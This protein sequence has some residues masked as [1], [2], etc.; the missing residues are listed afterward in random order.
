[1]EDIVIIAHFC[2]DL[3][4]EGNNRF[5][6]LANMLA[7][8]GHKIEFITSDFSHGKKEKRDT[9]LAL[10][11][12][13]T[14]YIK[15][16]SYKKNISIRR[17]YSHHALGKHL[18][19]YLNHRDKPS[20]IYCAVPSLSAAKAAA[21]YA[22]KNSIP[23]VIDIQDLWPEAFQMVLK[24]PKV[25]NML[26]APMKHQADSIYKKADAIIGV[27]D[28]YVNRGLEKNSK[29]R[30]GYSIY[31]GTDLDV[32]DQMI[33][34]VDSKSEDKIILAYVGTLGHSYDIE[35]TID[36]IVELKSRG[37]D[38]L[39]LVVMGDGPF[40]NQF[41]AYARSKNIDVEFT[42]KI[43]YKKMVNRLVSADIAVNPIHK[44][45]AATIINKVGDYAAAG[46]PVINTQESSEYR[47]LLERYKAGLNCLNG[48]PQDMADKIMI[49]YEDDQLRKQMGY[50]NRIL[51]EERFDRK[52][53][54]LQ[55]EHMVTHL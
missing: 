12:C 47:D 42:G 24:I 20:L 9:G 8:A 2:S 18:K 44:G 29:C 26:L 14:T 16:P 39:K 40:R 54:Y 10:K 3:D 23:L 17:F 13:K 30:R 37:I 5:N 19:T 38:N 1:M 53:T 33:V 6:Y 22:E 28:T 15:E 49:L 34:P 51:A 45:S 46:L 11:H 50:N 36:A 43:S 4:E 32:F 35:L 31:L 52:K 27:S 21:D 25:S 7:T 41:E 48:N 55:I